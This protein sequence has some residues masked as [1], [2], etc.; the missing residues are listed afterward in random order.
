M[1]EP[2]S[3]NPFVFNNCITVKDAAFLSG[4]NTQYL[5]RML[6]SGV[7]RG[8]KIGQMWIVD[9]AALDL[10]IEKAQVSTDQRFGPK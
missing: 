3:T 7:L 8:V 4:Y 6:R 1:C 9:K 5:R 2:G 10:Y